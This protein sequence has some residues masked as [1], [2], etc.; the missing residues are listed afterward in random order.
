VPTSSLIK[1]PFHL[2]GKSVA[3]STN[4]SSTHAGA[5]ALQKHYRV[6]FKLMPT[7]NAAATMTAAMSG[8][9]DAG[10][11]GAP[12]GVDALETG[13]VRLIMKS[14]DAP[15]FDKQTTRVIVANANDF[16]ARRDVYVRFMRGYRDS[17]R[18]IYS[19]PEGVRAFAAFAGLSEG[20]AA[21]SLREFLP[22]RAVNPD[23]LS[24]IPEVMADAVTFKFMP[25]PLTDA[26]L[27]EL[28]QIPERKQ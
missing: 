18:W 26:Q 11:A 5:M 12:F 24:G 9:V 19:T 17:L 22:P 10:W 1:S 16:A 27:D 4:G 20:A 21:R 28:I 25:A 3:Y 23:G 8:Q 13:R 14:S 6:N 15:D 7:G 2:D